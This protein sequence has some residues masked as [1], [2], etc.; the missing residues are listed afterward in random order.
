MSKLQTKKLKSENCRT[1]AVT[2]TASSDWND[3]LMFVK[4]FFS[5]KDISTIFN[6]K[7]SNDPRPYAKVG[8]NKD[9]FL[10]GLLDSGS[11]VTILGKNSHELLINLGLILCNDER[12][13]VTAAGG[14]RITSLGYILLPL[15]FEN[16]FSIIKA[17]II[18]AIETV[19]I[20]GIDFWN[21]FNLCPKYL[22]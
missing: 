10:Y 7:P 18:P 15:T 4:N 13:T 16:K 12:I 20:L 1:H 8:I 22:S 11:A 14:Q 21:T 6:V 17:H 9:L 19:L 3:W 2:H 5:R